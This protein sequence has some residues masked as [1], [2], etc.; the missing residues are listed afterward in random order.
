MFI[1]Y[2]CDYNSVLRIKAGGDW[3]AVGVLA[4]KGRFLGL[5]G[6]GGCGG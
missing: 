5:P 3:S 6:K 4:L 1:Y 2:N